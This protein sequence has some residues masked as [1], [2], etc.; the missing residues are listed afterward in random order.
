MRCSDMKRVLFLCVGNSCRSQMA[1]ALF[2][3]HAKGK[4]EAKSAGTRPAKEIAGLAVEAMKEMGIDI[5]GQKPKPL[6]EELMEWADTF[7]SMG[8]GVEDSCPVLYLPKFVDWEIEDPFGGTIGNYRRARDD[9]EEKVKR[10]LE[11]I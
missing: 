8:C 7:I 10:L 9:I 4:A 1:E 3:H 2:R 5:S 11:T 6:T